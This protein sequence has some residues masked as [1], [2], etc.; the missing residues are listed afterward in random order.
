MISSGSE[1]DKAVEETWTEERLEV[2]FNRRKGRLEYKGVMR[3]QRDYIRLK[4][5]MILM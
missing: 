1:N 5:G 4:F 3:T 2:I